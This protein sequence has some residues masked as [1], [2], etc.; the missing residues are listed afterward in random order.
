M[1]TVRYYLQ[2]GTGWYPTNVK[3]TWNTSSSTYYGVLGSPS[4]VSATAVAATTVVNNSTTMLMKLVSAPLAENST[5]DLLNAIIGFRQSNVNANLY[6]RLHCYITQGDTNTQR[7]D[8]IVDNW[9]GG[10]EFGSNTTSATGLALD[11]TSTVRTALAGDRIVIEVGFRQGTTTSGRNG[12]VYYGGS[13]GELTAGGNPTTAFGWVDFDI[14]STHQYLAIDDATH[15]HAAD[16]DLLLG[17]VPIPQTWYATML[18]AQSLVVAEATHTHLADNV[19]LGT[20]HTLAVDDCA[21]THLADNVVI[22]QYAGTTQTWYATMLLANASLTV[23]DASHTHEA[24]AVDLAQYVAYTVTAT[25]EHQLAIDDASHT[26]LA[27]NVTIGTSRQLVIDDAAHTHLADNVA[28]AQKHT[29]AAA[30]ATHTHTADNVTITYYPSTPL[31]VADATHTHLADAVA[32]TQLHQLTIADCVHTHLADNVTITYYGQTV[33]GIDDA[34]HL[35]LADSVILTQTGP[36]QPES[37]PSGLHI[38]VD[39]AGTS[40]VVGDAT[41]TLTVTASPYRRLEVDV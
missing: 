13:S 21:H 25:P 27:D 24:D 7:G 16:G 35:H 30:D 1:S 29:L 10:T 8:A 3:G 33:L 15:T 41:T 23:A 17:G 28:L 31:Y 2:N 38:I 22:T 32:L 34:V 4:G 5:V 18:W 6:P 37:G 12:Y 36:Y 19:G 11:P 39:T 20:V 26:H 9:V 40:L 14:T